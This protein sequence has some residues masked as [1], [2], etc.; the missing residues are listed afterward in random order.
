M[1]DTNRPPAALALRPGLCLTLLCLPFLPST[2]VAPKHLVTLSATLVV[3]LTMGRTVLG[4]L[5]IKKH[6]GTVSSTEKKQAAAAGDHPDDGGTR[7]ACPICQEPVGTLTAEGVLEG[8][9]MLPCGHVFGDFCIK[10]YLAIT[11][12]DQP[13]CPMC[14][15]A[16]Y[17]DVCG[18]PVLPFRLRPDG[19]HPDLVT[20][21]AGRRRPPVG[22]DALASTSCAYCQ[23]PPN[24]DADADADAEVEADTKKFPRAV[25]RRLLGHLGQLGHISAWKGPL[26]WLRAVVPFARKPAATTIDLGGEE[27]PAPTLQPPA[28]SATS[29][30]TSRRLTRQEARTRRRTQGQGAAWEGPWMDA[31]QTRDVEWEMWWKEQAPCGA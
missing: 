13:V 16:A 15:H 2:V 28:A 20:D 30:S 21:A 14:R 12:N 8:W 25:R 6:M 10:R 11:A 27:D 24:D 19:D 5:D 31:V 4:R 17:H 29:G 9:S 3:A 1:S 18:H 22:V 23:S 26:R 7:P